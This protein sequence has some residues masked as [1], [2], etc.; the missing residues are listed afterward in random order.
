[1]ASLSWLSCRRWAF[2]PR[3]IAATIDTSPAAMAAAAA[4]AL[5]P[6]G[7]GVGAASCS[8]NGATP[9]LRPPE[10]DLAGSRLSDK[11]GRIRGSF[12][13][14]KRIAMEARSGNRRY[15]AKPKQNR[16]ARAA[17]ASEIAQV[18]T[19][20]EPELPAVERLKLSFSIILSYDYKPNRHCS[21]GK[22]SDCLSYGE[23][24]ADE[25]Q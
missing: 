14:G 6:A 2:L 9:A 18:R 19:Q 15:R 24:S 8:I 10:A 23:E 13:H 17:S 1:M 20:H 25:W 12:R 22:S 7:V 21:L 5:P 16:E 4:E 11:L 3:E